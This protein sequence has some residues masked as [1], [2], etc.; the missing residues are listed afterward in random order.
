MSITD[1]FDEFITPA[2]PRYYR[3]D[4]DGYLVSIGVGDGGTEITAEEYD[5]LLALIADKPAP[6]EGYDYRLTS[7]LEWEQHEL[8]VA[9]DPMDE[10]LDAATAATVIM[11]VMSGA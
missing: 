8:P 9:P 10:V 3:E 5:N 2:P 6:P 11:E 1:L 4:V 7:E